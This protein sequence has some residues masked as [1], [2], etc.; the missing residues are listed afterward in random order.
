MASSGSATGAVRSRV[1]RRALALAVAWVLGP[2]LGLLLPAAGP[3]A[4]DG[5]VIEYVDCPKQF[6]SMTDRT[7]SAWQIQ[8][9]D[10][11][12]QVGE[13]N[14]LALDAAGQPHISYCAH[15]L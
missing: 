9:V 7:R 10:T 3:V 15:R 5:W 8:W 2:L 1:A 11:E 14:S 4:A 12:G 6:Y 13:Y